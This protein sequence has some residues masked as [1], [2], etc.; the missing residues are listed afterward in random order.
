VHVE[1]P[2]EG[3][4]DGAE[5]TADAAVVPEPPHLLL[6]AGDGGEIDGHGTPLTTDAA[7]VSPL[8]RTAT[9]DLPQP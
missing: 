1:A 7:A 5:Q 9:T 3:L 4:A 2:N 6:L 8:V